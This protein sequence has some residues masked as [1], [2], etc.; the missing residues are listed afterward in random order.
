LTGA[1]PVITTSSDINGMLSPDMLALKYGA[2]IDDMKQCRELTA[3]QVNGGTIAL[4]S[5][6]AIALPAGYVLP[7]S[8]ADGIIY[9]TNRVL[10]EKNAPSL[11]LIPR[12]IVIG[13]GCR[14]G[15]DTDA[16]REFIFRELDALGIDRRAVCRVAS[17]DIKKDEPAIRNAAKFLNAE[18]VF[19]PVEKI[20][21]V[22]QLFAC[23]DFVRE[24]TGAGCVAEPCAYLASGGIG[25]LRLPKKK[26]N[27]MTIAVYEKPLKEIL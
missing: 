20:K 27:G 2:A 16:L 3:L 21:D 4:R 25:T 19:F 5:D 6:Y 18:A 10:K 14:S 22:E 8:E 13:T 1:V 17:I 7:D 23:S 24:K 9:L 15:T 11:Q 26:K 12:N